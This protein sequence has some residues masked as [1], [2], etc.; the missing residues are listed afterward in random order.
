[1]NTEAVK[2]RMMTRKSGGYK[3]YENFN[4]WRSSG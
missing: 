2:G 4:D 3:D 1:M